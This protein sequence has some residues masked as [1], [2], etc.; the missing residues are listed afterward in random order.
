ME[1]SHVPELNARETRQLKSNQVEL[2]KCLPCL[3]RLPTPISLCSPEPHRF[4]R[5]LHPCLRSYR[6]PPYATPS[7]RF[8][9]NMAEQPSSSPSLTYACSY[10]PKLLWIPLPLFPV[11]TFAAG[12]PRGW[13]VITCRRSP[14]SLA[15]LLHFGGCKG[16]RQGGSVSLPHLQIKKHQMFY[17]FCTKHVQTVF[18]SLFQI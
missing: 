4:S 7:F 3:H 6:L 14:S 1:T 18:F 9:L 16:Q 13:E 5:W 12:P 2:H 10:H 17:C 15:D 11:C 8:F